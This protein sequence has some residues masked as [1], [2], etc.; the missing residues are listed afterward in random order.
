M[1]NYKYGWC[2]GTKR[3]ESRRKA[4]QAL[5][6]IAVSILLTTTAVTG[7][8]ETS[9]V[10]HHS[11]TITEIGALRSDTDT[12]AAF[13]SKFGPADRC[14]GKYSLS[15]VVQTEDGDPI[16]NEQVTVMDKTGETVFTGFTDNAG[17]INVTLPQGH[18]DVF[19]QNQKKHVN[20]NDD[21]TVSFTL[22]GEELPET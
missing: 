22:S 11:N 21:T 7:A 16:A 2:I 8:P 19:V 1:I 17:Q 5:S 13:L 6:I 20:L 12:R 9:T 3:M 18:Y 10:S 15:T 14:V 4:V